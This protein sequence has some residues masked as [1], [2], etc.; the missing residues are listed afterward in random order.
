M[1]GLCHLRTAACFVSAAHSPSRG[2]FDGVQ[3]V[4]VA[5][6]C[7]ALGMWCRSPTSVVQGFIKQPL[8]WPVCVCKS[9]SCAY[10]AWMRR[11]Q[12]GTADPEEAEAL[13]RAPVPLWDQKYNDASATNKC[14]RLTHLCVVNALQA[15]VQFAMGSTV[16]DCCGGENDAIAVR[17]PLPSPS[18][19]LVHSLSCFRSGSAA[20]IAPSS[21][22]TLSNAVRPNIISMLVVRTSSTR[23]LSWLSTGWSH[24][25]LT[26]RTNPFPSYPTPTASPNEA[27]V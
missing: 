9:T 11:F 8:V 17:A 7:A 26:T 13:Q 22:T 24:P 14:R 23:S 4:S 2:L 15:H 21:L 27:C 19:P 5:S 3:R 25:H 10:Y 12:T 1:F 6:G 18:V 20:R 16:L